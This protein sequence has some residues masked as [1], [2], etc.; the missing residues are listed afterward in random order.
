MEDRSSKK[1]G[2]LWGNMGNMEK[3]AK[4]KKIPRRLPD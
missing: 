4:K 1:K 3:I 2:K